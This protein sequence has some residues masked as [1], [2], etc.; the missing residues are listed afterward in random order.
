MLKLLTVAL[1]GVASAGSLQGQERPESPDGYEREELGVNR[2][3]APSIAKIFEQLDQ[4]KP[5][6]YEQMKREFPSSRSASREHRG[7]I[8]GGLVADGFLMVEAE[9]KADVEELGRILIREARGLGVAERV[10]RH[11]AS[12]TEKA[13]RGEWTAV[14]AELVVTQTDVEQAMIELRDQSM[15]HLISLGGWLR[16]LEI[17]ASAVGDDFSA[18][19]ARILAQPELVQYFTAEVKTFSPQLKTT[20]LFQKLRSG[21]ERISAVLDKATDEELTLADVKTLSAEARELNLAIRR[22][23]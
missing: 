1:A 18:E 4:L 12:L 16:G 15:A 22:S 14:R 3:T 11:S 13:K 9:R 20:P 17:S 7:L 6:S 19:R 2:Y 10:M 21:L 23:D 5:F 8:F